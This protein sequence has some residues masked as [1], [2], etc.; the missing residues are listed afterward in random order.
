MTPL[1]NLALKVKRH[2]EAHPATRCTL[3]VTTDGT[4]QAMLALPDKIKPD[5]CEF[6][7]EMVA[8]IGHAAGYGIPKTLTPEERDAVLSKFTGKFEVTW[9]DHDLKKTN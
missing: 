3:I 1:E 9:L 8:G 4:G 2:V 7:S 5:P 6:L